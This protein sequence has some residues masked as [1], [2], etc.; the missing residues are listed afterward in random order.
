MMEVN[1]GKNIQIK[2]LKNIYLLESQRRIGVPVP[3]SLLKCLRQPR[4]GEVEVE[5]RS[6]ELHPDFPPGW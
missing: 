3:G 1:P 4:L 2:V 6:L 5:T